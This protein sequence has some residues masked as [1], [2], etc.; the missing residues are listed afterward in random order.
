[1]KRYIH[2]A[3]DTDS[4]PEKLSNLPYVFTLNS[5]NSTY[6][7][8]IL[9]IAEHFG[10]TKVKYQEVNPKTG[11]LFIEGYWK[12][13]VPSEEVAQSIF[14]EVKKRNIPTRQSD[15]QVVKTDWNDNYNI[16]ID[17]YTKGMKKIP[18]N[19]KFKRA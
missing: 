10:A 8:D 6:N 11:N 17:D 19:S 4:I 1:M 18:F 3:K 15:I 5:E 7:D 12:F 13:A 14:D 9:E 2:A 16:Y